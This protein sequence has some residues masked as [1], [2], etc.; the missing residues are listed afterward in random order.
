MAASSLW[1][2]VYRRRSPAGAF[3]SSALACRAK[4]FA[5]SL[6]SL[7]RP[8]SER[9]C[10]PTADPSLQTNEYFSVN[11]VR[12]SRRT[13]VVGLP[14]TISFRHYSTALPVE[15]ASR[16]LLHFPRRAV[17]YVPASEERKV[18]KAASLNVDTLVFDIEDGVAVN[19]KVK[20]PNLRHN[21][22]F[23]MYVLLFFTIFHV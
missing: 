2:A 16:A 12:S 10:R 5:T 20:F 3:K 11:R 8:G 9:H 7:Y 14:G 6:S 13:N 17:M 22:L 15:N 18:K 21:E 19:Q 23:P 1:R 4:L